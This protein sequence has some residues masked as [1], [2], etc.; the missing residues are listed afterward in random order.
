MKLM[1]VLFGVSVLLELLLHTLPFLWTIRRAVAVIA[2]VVALGSATA[3]CVLYPTA[4]MGVLVV[5]SLYRGFNAIRIIKERMHD[6]YLRQATRRTSWSIIGVQIAV[7]ISWW[8]WYQ[9]P[10]DRQTLWLSLSLLQVLVAAVLLASIVRRIN[11]THPIIDTKHHYSD[12]MLPSVTVAI[13]ARNETQDLQECLESLVAS[14]YPK[15]EI[16]V[17]DDCSQNKHTPE[18][19][20]S[21]AHDGVRFIRGDEPRPTWLAKNQAYDRLAQ[22]ASGQYVLFCGVDIRFAPDS[23]RKL[24]SMMLAKEKRMISILPHLQQTERRMPIL[25]AMRYWW[26]L[27][28]PRRLFGRPPVLSSC[29]MIERKALQQVGGFAA[30][31]RAIVPE[32]YFAKAMVRDD[33]Y[34]FMRSNTVLGID[35]VKQTVEQY[36]TAIRTR[37]PQLHRRPEQVF[38]TTI[39]EGLFLVVPF[40]MALAGWWLPI[41]G[42]THLCAVLASILLVAS[43]ECMARASQLDHW[44]Y[45]L[46]V[47]PIMVIADIIV[48]HES[49]WRYEFSEVVWK[50]RNVCIPVMHT[51]PHLPKI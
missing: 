4:L 35:S 36:D 22:E 27:V 6:R 40:G 50:D 1:V 33:R 51:T 32:A 28:P 34:S 16:I 19:I 24:V 7:L 38:M 37:Y 20:R 39:A 10:A 25:Q 47:L 12:A 15:L 43:Y 23:L 5:A 2:A 41:T 13:P 48:I 44:R 26:E 14:D 8:L 3:L 42:L 45:G 46:V 31:T 11:R 30:V 21:F 9:A 29:W 17:L 49:M 18:I